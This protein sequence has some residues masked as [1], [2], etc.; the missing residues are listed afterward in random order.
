MEPLYL[1]LL[2]LVT[3]GTALYNAFFSSSFLSRW[4]GGVQVAWRETVK[5]AEVPACSSVLLGS[6]F[7]PT[8]P[9]SSHH[10]PKD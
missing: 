4:L 8:G 9:C 1:F 6:A 7:L 5:E 2:L 3:G 10:P